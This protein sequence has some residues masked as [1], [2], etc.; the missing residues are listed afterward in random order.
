MFENK[1]L[2][3]KGTYAETSC[4]N[5]IILSLGYIALSISSSSGLS[6]FVS[7]YFF[8]YCFKF[9]A[10]QVNPWI[11]LWKIP[12]KKFEALEIPDEQNIV[13]LFIS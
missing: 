5:G 6:G 9:K 12:P 11:V 7:F 1:S 2:K 13:V 10:L 3:N 4:N 8:V